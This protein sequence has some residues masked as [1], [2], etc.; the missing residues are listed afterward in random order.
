MW[1]WRTHQRGKE[2][3]PTLIRRGRRRMR[4]CSEGSSARREHIW[5]GGQPVQWVKIRVNSN[6]LFFETVQPLKITLLGVF[7]PKPS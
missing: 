6:Q 5:V 1:D 4:R 2:K 7:S 3:K